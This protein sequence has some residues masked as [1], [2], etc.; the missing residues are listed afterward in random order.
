MVI[1]P[2]WWRY[3]CKDGLEVLPRGNLPQ[4]SLLAGAR[5]GRQVAW[6]PVDGPIGQRCK[7]DRLLGV[8]IETQG[9]VC[10]HAGRGQNISEDRHRRKKSVTQQLQRRAF[11]IH[12]S[13][14]NA[15]GRRTRHQPNNLQETSLLLQS[16]V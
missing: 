6:P 11:N 14:V 5:T 4:R 3:G 1:S 8:A 9:L 7:C 12:D 10:D 15:V 13:R 2:R 16:R